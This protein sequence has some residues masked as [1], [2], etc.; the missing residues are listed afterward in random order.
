MY[1]YTRIV[2]VFLFFVRLPLLAQEKSAFEQR[3][4][5]IQVQLQYLGDSSA[6]G[7]S[8]DVDLS[9]SGMPVQTFLRTIAEAHNL[10]IQVD[11]SLTVLLTNNFSKVKVLDLFYFLCQEYQLDIKF[12]GNIMSF[13]KFIEPQLPIVPSV[14]RSLDIQFNPLTNSLSFNLK[15]DDL[16]KVVEEIT[17][18]SGRNVMHSGGDLSSKRLNGLVRNLPFE[19]A[20]DKLAYV[21]AMRL[22][23]TKDGVY[24]FEN[25]INASQNG[26]PNIASVMNQ[27]SRPEPLGEI[28]VKDSLIDVN[29]INYP[30]MDIVEHV[31]KELGKNYVLFSEISGNTTA[32]VK[33]VKFDYL[34]SF[35]FQGTQYTYKESNG[36]YLIGQRNQEGFRTTEVVKLA[37]RTID[38][39]EKEIPADL[40]KD[41]EIKVFKELNS[42]IITG[43]KYKINEIVSF[44]KLID[45]PVPNILIEVIVADARKGFNLQTGIKAI[46]SDSIPKTQGQV[47]PGLDL[48]LS[49]PSIN[50]A[51]QNLD[52]KGIV[53]LGRVSPSFYLNLQ[54]LEENNNIQIRSTPK[55]S[56]IN[57]S[58]AT[59]II[60]ESLYYIE[61]TQ[62][63]TGGVNPITTTAQRF[64]KVE[65]NLSI[66]ISP[67]V[68]G[69]EHITLDITA[70]FSNFV[71]PTIKSAPPGNAT[72]KFES[73][74]RVKNEEMIIL[75]GLEE[76]SKSES[77]SGTPLLSRI[78]I[79]KWL[80]SSRV[81]KNSE[82]RLI[83]FIKP[84]LVY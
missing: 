65:A 33:K 82:N 61:Q 78:P 38:G 36:V 55:L 11:P 14:P 13:K 35:L 73:K 53:N 10:N 44:L 52:A 2:F 22:N 50:R 3:L 40:A 4:D 45:Q 43:N 64:N 77:A 80:F 31:T 6:T 9:V 75:G 1:P 71:P 74:I 76:V 48:T 26:N 49:P 56:T 41:M 29:V 23:K 8:Q 47:F 84:T 16:R 42:L 20:L 66:A 59:L 70:E 30:I 58:K 67:M 15:D 79:L 81:K 18:L 37:F 62:N 5:E 51:L 17:I 68:S 21:N 7:L 27:T 60:G 63:I 39:I 69:N 19:T 46:L 24:I 12:I 28:V 34:L 54:A 25:S 57:G 32:H 83:V 72:R